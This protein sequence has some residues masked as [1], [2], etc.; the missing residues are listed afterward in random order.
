V[1]PAHLRAAGSSALPTVYLL[2]ATPLGGSGLG[3]LA[4]RCLHGGKSA[5]E[6]RDRRD[7]SRRPKRNI[8]AAPRLRCLR[9]GAG[10]LDRPL[11]DGVGDFLPPLL[12]WKQVG[13]ALVLGR[14]PSPALREDE[15]SFVL[16]AGV[17]PLRLREGEPRLVL[18]AK[19]S[20]RRTMHPVGVTPQER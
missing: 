8:R 16:E 18:V 1:R 9:P 17:R 4:A 5:S 15:Y 7:S 6:S 14:S 12:R 10:V 2:G 13:E 11:Q 3:Q 20:V 19:S